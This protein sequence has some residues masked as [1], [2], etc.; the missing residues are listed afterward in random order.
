LERRAFFVGPNASGKSN[1]LDALR[2]L[3]DIVAVGG[4]LREAVRARGNVAE[5]RSFAATRNANVRTE[6]D[7]GDDTT[8][9]R[10]TYALEFAARKASGDPYVVNESVLEGVSGKVVLSRPDAVDAADEARLSQT[11]LEQVNSNKPFREIADFLSSISYLHVVPQIVRDTSRSIGANDPFGGDL[12]ERINA[13]PKRTRDSRLQIMQEVL[14]IAVPQLT[15]LELEV[16]KKGVPHL[17]A[18]Y[19]HWRPQ[20]AWQ[21]QDRFSDGTLRLLGLIWALQESTG[22]L[23]LE[24]PEMSLNAALV[25]ALAPMIAKAARRSRRQVLITTHSADLL[26]DGVDLSEVHLLQVSD[27]GTEICSSGDLE[28]VR[29]LVEGGVPLGEAILPK[30]KAKGIERLPLLELMTS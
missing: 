7:I 20:G 4:G 27:Q 14:Q 13:T 22:P 30:S 1:L 23:L 26:A 8:P 9:S 21:R 6:V 28:D 24:E 16:D 3:R 29:R 5:I 15:D 19:V 12:V 18:R 2:F 10:W 11:A 17:R 25:S